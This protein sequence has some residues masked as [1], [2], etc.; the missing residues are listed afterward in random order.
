MAAA[1]V[2]EVERLRMPAVEVLHPGGEPRLRRLHDE[3][4]VV[5]H[6]T[7]DVDAPAVSAGRPVEQPHPRLAVFA[8]ADDCGAVDASDEDVKRSVG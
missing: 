1:A 3:V 6:Q 4:E 5:R 7:P 8:V 2:A